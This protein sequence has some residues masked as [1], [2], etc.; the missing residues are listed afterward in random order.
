L[1]RLNRMPF[2]TTAYNFSA[3]PDDHRDDRGHHRLLRLSRR[4]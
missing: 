1:C 3:A 4:P 2:T